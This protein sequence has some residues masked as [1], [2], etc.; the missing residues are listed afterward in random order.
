MRCDECQP[1]LC[2][3]LLSRSH[4][5]DGSILPDALGSLQLTWNRFVWNSSFPE[6]IFNSG[7]SAFKLANSPL[8]ALLKSGMAAAVLIPAPTIQ[9]LFFALASCTARLRI[10]SL[11]TLMLCMFAMGSYKGKG[12]AR[13]FATD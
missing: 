8:S 10:S 9:A 4:P 2:L 12:K 3:C 6:L 1:W 11:S 7:F 5:I 13:I